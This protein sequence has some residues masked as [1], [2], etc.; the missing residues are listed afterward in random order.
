MVD[1]VQVLLATACC[2]AASVFCVFLLSTEKLLSGVTDR[3][4][5][6]WQTEIRLKTAGVFL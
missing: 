6:M 1:Y 3:V 4:L 5:Q 2:E